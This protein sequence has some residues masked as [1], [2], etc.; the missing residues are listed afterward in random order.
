V[1]HQGLVDRPQRQPL[2][3]ARVSVISHTTSLVQVATGGTASNSVAPTDTSGPW[4]LCRSI[5]E[6]LKRS[7]VQLISS[8]RVLNRSGFGPETRIGC[9]QLKHDFYA[10]RNLGRLSVVLVTRYKSGNA[11]KVGNFTSWSFVR[12]KGE[13]TLKAKQSSPA[14]QSIPNDHPPSSTHP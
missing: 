6:F 7:P 4:L 3:A 2:G 9:R 12:S 8:R 11:V 14:E 10:D 1:S 13:F 5:Q